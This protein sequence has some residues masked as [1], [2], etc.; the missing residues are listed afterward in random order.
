VIES[1][2]DLRLDRSKHK[3]IWQNKFASCKSK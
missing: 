2:P 1:T 3:K